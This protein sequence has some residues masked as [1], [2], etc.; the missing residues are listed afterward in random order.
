M[1]SGLWIFS[2]GEGFR[3]ESVHGIWKTAIMPASVIVVSCG[4]FLHPAVASAEFLT[5]F[6]PD[7]SPCYWVNLE[8]LA[9]AVRFDVGEDTV[10]LDEVWLHYDV[11]DSVGVY[12]IRDLPDTTWPSLIYKVGE[13]KI[14]SEYE[15]RWM[16]IDI[17]HAGIEVSDTV[18]VLLANRWLREPPGISVRG[19]DPSPPY[20]SYAESKIEGWGPG[21]CHLGIGILVNEPAG[22]EREGGK[23][24]IPR[25]L[26]EQNHPNPF[27]PSTTITFEL[28]PGETRSVELYIH[29]LRGKLVRKLLDRPFPP[30]RHSV[31][32]D[33]KDEKGIDAPSGIYFYTLVT[34]GERRTGKMI[35]MK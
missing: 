31:V 32:W 3:W 13:I 16:P 15:D 33:G 21:P 30:G 20:N 17:R 22:I 28:P 2:L 8:F 5:E 1:K 7:D 23:G 19:W 12:I 4:M 29:D 14:P 11:Q 25:L 34:G 18:W 26:L 35:L 10:S 9:E 24:E 6:D 27:N